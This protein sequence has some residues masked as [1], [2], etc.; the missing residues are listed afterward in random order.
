ML[1]TKRRENSVNCRKRRYAGKGKTQPRT[2]GRETG[3]AL[4][5]EYEDPLTS[6]L[7]LCAVL[8]VA[9]GVCMLHRTELIL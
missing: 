1:R 4:A 5:A 6:D 9:G 7:T 3:N 2:Q 8:V